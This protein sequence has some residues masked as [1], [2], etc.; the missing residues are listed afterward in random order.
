M[1]KQT[2]DNTVLRFQD[3]IS[4][5]IYLAVARPSSRIH[6]HRPNNSSL[7]S[8]IPRRLRNLADQWSIAPSRAYYT[9]DDMSMGFLLC[10]IYPDVKMNAQD[11]LT[12]QKRHILFEKHRKW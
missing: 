4:G 10:A 6:F 2:G 12:F 5:N 7:A 8:K 1:K 9:M 11:T 3:N